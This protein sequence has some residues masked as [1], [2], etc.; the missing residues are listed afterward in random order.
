MDRL[1]ALAGPPT[2]RRRR[3][4]DLG[5]RT[6]VLITGLVL[7]VTAVAVAVT[8]PLSRSD[9]AGAPG[10][11]QIGWSATRS[12]SDTVAHISTSGGAGGSRL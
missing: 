1:W 12:G 11:T 10:P 2:P 4:D 7:A 6:R 3:I 5:G 9:R 8:V